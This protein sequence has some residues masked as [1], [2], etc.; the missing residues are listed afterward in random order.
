MGRET[1]VEAPQKVTKPIFNE[2]NMITL[3]SSTS[4]KC[5]SQCIKVGK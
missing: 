3:M 1:V 4:K 2:M 5:L